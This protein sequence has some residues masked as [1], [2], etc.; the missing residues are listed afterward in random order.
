MD[1]TVRSDGGSKK[2][3]ETIEAATMRY[4]IVTGSNIKL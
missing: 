3:T 2:A 4:E 1:I